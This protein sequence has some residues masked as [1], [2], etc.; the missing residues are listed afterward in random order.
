MQL[1]FLS[2]LHNLYFGLQIFDQVVRISDFLV[3]LQLSTKICIHS[4]MRR[5]IPIL[6]WLEFCTDC[7]SQW[8][9]WDWEWLVYRAAT[10]FYEWSVPQIFDWFDFPLRGDEWK[11]AKGW[12]FEDESEN[13][14]NMMIKRL[15]EV[16]LARYLENKSSGSSLLTCWQGLRM[17]THHFQ[18]RNRQRPLN[19][20]F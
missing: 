19:L 13:N 3:H 10:F 4:I 14:S 18:S 16:H 12:E 20:P 1:L 5:K 8:G 7:I 17:N 6:L 15:N 11:F 9:N 2:P